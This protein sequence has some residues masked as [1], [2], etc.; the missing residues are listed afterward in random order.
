MLGIDFISVRRIERLCGREWYRRFWFTDAELERLRAMPDPG[1]SCAAAVAMKEAV[2]KA[3]GRGFRQGV[4]PTMVT[5]DWST[6]GSPRAS[7]GGRRF[8]ITATHS[9]GYALAAALDLGGAR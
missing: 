7:L 9:D 3:S 8:A 5:L 1:E 4:R 6:S 2:M